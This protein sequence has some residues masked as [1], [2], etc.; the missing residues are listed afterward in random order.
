M[1]QGGHLRRVLAGLG[2]V[3]A[4]LAAALLSAGPSMR[5]AVLAPKD[6]PS[7]PVPGLFV[8]AGFYAD[9]GTADGLQEAEVALTSAVP[10]PGFVAVRWRGSTGDAHPLT[11]RWP[12]TSGPIAGSPTVVIFPGLSPA[13][14][15]AALSG[16]AEVTV[17][18]L[19]GK[20]ASCQIGP[21]P[22]V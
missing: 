8:C 18:A 20:R 12:I 2:A 7:G 22:A 21:A 11:A 16:P 4:L 17:S 19:N 1:S 9:T 10:G 3:V 15:N 13:R 5:S 14:A 6:A